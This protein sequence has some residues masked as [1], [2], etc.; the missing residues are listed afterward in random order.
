[1]HKQVA[2]FGV[3][4]GLNGCAQDLHTV[5]LQ[6]PFL[7]ERYAAVECCLTTKREQ[8]AVGTFL[9]DDALDELGSHGLEIDSIGN[10][11]RGRVG[12]VI[13]L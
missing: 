5:F 1:M 6:Y 11:L 4:D 12:A 3:D 2:V 7:I 10:S 8:D 13:L 9:L